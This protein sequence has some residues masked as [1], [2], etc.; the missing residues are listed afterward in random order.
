MDVDRRDA[1]D[2]G[3][4]DS[5]R[6]WAGSSQRC[7]RQRLWFFPKRC[8]A[9]N[10]HVQ[11]G[12]SMKDVRHLFLYARP[13]VGVL[14]TAAVISLAIVI[15][16]TQSRA[17][18]NSPPN[19]RQNGQSQR[20]EERRIQRDAVRRLSKIVDEAKQIGDPAARVRV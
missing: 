7:D 17:E 1:V 13:E 15:V 5:G 6:A 9:H 16:Q 12:E 10:L 3:L 4:P 2:A 19:T 14:I 8:P 18:R 11:S 20:S